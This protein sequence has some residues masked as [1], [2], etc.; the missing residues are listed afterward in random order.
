[1][2]VIVSIPTTNR[3]R[4]VVPT[5]RDIER[6]VRLPDLVLIVVADEDDIDA[7]AL[8]DLPFEVSIRKSERELTSQRN[9]AVTLLEDDDLLWW[10]HVWTAPVLQGLN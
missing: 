7:E 5:V 1:M 8:R 4:V 6:Q 9:A 3:S 10:C 2:R